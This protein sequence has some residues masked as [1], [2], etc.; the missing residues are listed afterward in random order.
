MDTQYQKFKSLTI[1][2]IA[3]TLAAAE[4][5]NV[6]AAARKLHVSQPA[7]SAAIAALEQHYGIKLFTRLPSKGISLTPFGAQVMSEA[8]LLCDQA[9]TVAVLATPDATIAGEVAICCYEALAPFVLPRLLRRL[10]QRLPAVSIR[11]SEADLENT[12]A[13]LKQGRADLAISYD[14]GIEGNADQQVLYSLQPHIICS[15]DHEFA[16]RKGLGLKELHRQKLILLDQPWSS[17]YV[18]GLLRAR[19]AEPDVVMRA[20]SFELHRSLV[21]NG[22]GVALVHTLPVSNLSYDGLPILAVPVT[23]T[24]IVQTVLL[25]CLTQNRNRPVLK[26]ILAEVA[27]LFSENHGS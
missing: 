9:Q 16:R 7:V 27:S 14:L 24:L 6:T 20:K 26:A 18:L 5:G 25:T 3:Y 23:D 4:E 1:K 15:K 13:N 10:Q 22:F 12:A 17:Q 21:A 19:G 8:R 2:Q 11:F